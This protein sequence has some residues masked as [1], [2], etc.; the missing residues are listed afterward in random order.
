MTLT[1]TTTKTPIVTGYSSDIALFASRYQQGGRTIYSLNLSLE[2]IA[3]LIE[4]PDPNEASE[5]NRRIRPKHGESFGRYVREREDWVSPSLMF[6]SA[7]TFDFEP[8][9]EE[10]GI[11]HGFTTIPRRELRDVHIVEGQHRVYGTVHALKQIAIDLDKAQSGLASTRKVDPG[12]RAEADARA[13]IASLQAQR[14]K[15]EKE[16]ISVQIVVESDPVAYRQM[17]FDIAD[18]QLGITASVKSRFDSRKVVNRALQLVLKHPLLEGR[19]DLEGDRTGRG[20][21]YL[22]GAKNVAET[23]RS[24]NVGLD[25]RVSKK[26]EHEFNEQEVARLAMNYYTTLVE[27]FPQLQALILGTATPDELRRTTLLSMLFLRILGGV[28][29]DLMNLHAFEREAVLDFFV[30][31][32]AHMDG[33]AYP[34]SIWM[35]EIPGD[36][37][38]EGSFGP[39]GS[40]KDLSTLK[41]ILVEWAITKPKFLDE[42][43]A[44]R[45]EP[46]ISEEDA[47]YGKG[48]LDF[49]ADVPEVHVPAEL[50]KPRPARKR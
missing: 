30:K 12:G 8:V 26:Q 45:P 28:Y 33:P 34:E 20:S 35:K 6:R 17:F 50:P 32:S 5:G 3:D 19:V 2:Q 40:K 1:Q 48:Y 47:E 22:M 46:E 16:H 13:L 18:N 36:I 42:P 44:P 24:V 39:R 29:H 14:K 38:L 41:S 7:K 4:P 10:P 27:S 25:G 9:V 37:Y 23:I 21:P 31:L 49:G 43:P 11:Q 15:F